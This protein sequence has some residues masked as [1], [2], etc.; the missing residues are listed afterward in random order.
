MSTGNG[1]QDLV[2]RMLELEAENRE[3]KKDVEYHRRNADKWREW[4]DEL[5]AGKTAPQRVDD[6]FTFGT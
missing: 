2:L 6:R 4:Y 5:K 3:L 1:T